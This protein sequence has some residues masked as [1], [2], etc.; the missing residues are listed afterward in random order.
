M[1]PQGREA[2]HA[3]SI[4]LG[5]LRAP[6]EPKFA[7]DQ[8]SVVPVDRYIEMGPD[9]PAVMDVGDIHRPTLVS[10]GIAPDAGRSNTRRCI[11]AGSGGLVMELTRHPPRPCH[12][13]VV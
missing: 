3:G 6:A 7:A 11:D 13:T 1:K 8:S 4:A 2:R 9:I 10:A 12:E 5:F